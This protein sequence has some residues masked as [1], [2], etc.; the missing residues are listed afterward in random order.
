VN[1][2]NFL[3]LFIFLSSHKLEFTY[4]LLIMRTI[5]LAA[6]IYS[7]EEEAFQRLLEGA[8]AINGEGAVTQQAAAIIRER[9]IRRYWACSRCLLLL[10]EKSQLPF[11]SFD[12]G[13]GERTECWKKKLFSGFFQKLQR[14]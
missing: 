9:A 11:N 14:D 7:T 12:R 5:P 3:Q 8:V 1:R 2:I 13:G 6:Q 10:F 4:L